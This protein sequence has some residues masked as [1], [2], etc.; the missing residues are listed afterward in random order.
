MKITHYSLLFGIPLFS[1][2]GHVYTRS[3]S[4]A[5]SSAENINQAQ[6]NA[7]FRPNGGNGGFSFSAMV[8]MAGATKLEGPFLWRIQAVGKKGMHQSMQIHRVQVET[9]KTKREEWFP[10]VHLN[11]KV[12]FRPF[13]KTPEKNYAY[14]QLPGEL[15]VNPQKDGKVTLTVDLTVTSNAK[16]E[17]RLLRFRLIPSKKN[18]WEFI[19]LPT[20]ISNS[21]HKD[22]REWKFR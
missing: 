7:A 1:S 14:F 12:P 8:Y 5:E 11:K 20:E 17:R 18:E 15:K 10:A 2:C 16:T 6:V 3:N 19:F 9:E 4:Y 22:P 21:F 13:K